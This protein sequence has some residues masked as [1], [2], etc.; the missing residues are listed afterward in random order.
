MDLER[1]KE[2]AAIFRA[3]CDLKGG[4]VVVFD[5][6][7]VGWVN[8]ANWVVELRN[9]QQWAPGNITIDESG[10]MWES[11]GG[12]EYD[13]AEEWKPIGQKAAGMPTVELTVR[14][15]FIMAAMQGLCGRDTISTT[16]IPALAVE[17]ADATLAEACK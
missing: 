15:R 9:P 2:V 11:V 16:N 5:G 17:I 14:Q 13:G 10:N 6:D 4:V 7:A 1:I 12:N 3:N 8:S